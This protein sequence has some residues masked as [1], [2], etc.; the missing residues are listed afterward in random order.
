MKT[1]TRFTT[2]H[3]HLSTGSYGDQD[4]LGDNHSRARKHYLLEGSTY[5][6]LSRAFS[7]DGDLLLSVISDSR[8]KVLNKVI[9]VA[10]SASLTSS[11]VSAFS[12]WCVVF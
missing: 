10:P 12:V 3:A 9:G 11:E 4:I 6:Q 5:N 7:E 2:L 8:M 1:L